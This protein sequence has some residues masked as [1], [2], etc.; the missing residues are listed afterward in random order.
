MK[1]IEVVVVVICLL[2]VIVGHNCRLLPVSRCREMV[3]SSAAR[4]PSGWDQVMVTD[5]AVIDDDVIV[6]AGK[7]V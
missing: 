6:G 3:Y 5:V 1:L 2:S 4:L 7:S